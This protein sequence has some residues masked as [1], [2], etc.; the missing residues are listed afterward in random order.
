MTIHRVEVSP[1]VQVCLI[2]TITAE[3]NPDELAD[4]LSQSINIQVNIVSYFP[5]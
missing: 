3:V 4:A 1:G 5:N 2:K